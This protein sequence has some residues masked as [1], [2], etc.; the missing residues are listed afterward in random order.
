M[1]D[2]EPVSRLPERKQLPE[3]VEIDVNT[4]M[5][6]HSPR[7][8]SLLRELTGKG[9]QELAGEDA[10]DGDRERVLVWFKLRRLGYEP[11]WEEA[12]DVLIDYVAA[13]PPSGGD[14]AS[15]PPS[16]GSGG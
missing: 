4:G 8:T 14:S 12:G 1:A 13:N 6:P 15:S 11:T 3:L 7:E 9:F 16:V 10:D 5:P 2:P